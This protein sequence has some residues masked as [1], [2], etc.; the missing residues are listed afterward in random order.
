MTC[1]HCGGYIKR[2]FSGRYDTTTQMACI[3]TGEEVPGDPFAAEGP[4]RELEGEALA[5]YQRMLRGERSR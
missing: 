1:D 4:F 3:C 2:G 5:E